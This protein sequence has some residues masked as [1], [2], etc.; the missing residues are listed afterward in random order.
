MSE[1]RKISIGSFNLYIGIAMVCV[2]LAHTIGLFPSDSLSIVFRAVFEV[3]TYVGVAG[4]AIIAGYKLRLPGNLKKYIIRTCKDYLKLYYAF[5][6]ITVLLFGIIHFLCFRYIPGTIKEMGLMATGFLFAVY[7]PIPVGDVTIYSCGPLYFIVAFIVAEVITVTILC[8]AKRYSGIIIAI[9]MLLGS[10]LMNV[11]TG[12]PFALSSAMLFTGCIYAGYL[13]REKSFFDKTMNPV[14]VLITT[15]ISVG[16]YLLKYI[17]ALKNFE[18]LLATIAGIFAGTILI[19][20]CILLSTKKN[21]FTSFM[22]EIGRVSFFVLG[23]HTIE[24]FSIPWYLIVEKM[25]GMPAELG[26]LVIYSIRLIIIFV[27]VKITV[28][29]YKRILSKNK[30]K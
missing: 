23:A 11:L 25:T 28:R 10:V 22:K 3:I 1:Q 6:L 18:F 30:K 17:P 2:V 26:V 8:L 12:C 21:R 19:N 4:F 20:Y 24:Y 14:A 16:I 5:G 29:I 7:P 15:V 13:L 9:T 27:I